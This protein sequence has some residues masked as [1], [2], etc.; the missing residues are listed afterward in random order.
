MATSLETFY[1][2]I[3]GDI[4]KF[5]DALNFEPSWQQKQLFDA[6]QAGH[7]RIAVKSGQGP[8][9]TAA[10]AVVALWRLLRAVDARGIVT[11][12]TMHQ[13]KDV[14]LAE[15]RL[16]LDRA[17]PILSQFF[18]VTKSKIEMC[19]R[20]DWGIKLMTASKDTNAQGQ[21]NDHLTF[22]AEEASGIERA[23]IQQIEGTLSQATGDSLFIQIGNPNTRDCAFFDC[24]NTKRQY[25]YT[26]TWNA[27]ESPHVHPEHHKGLAEEYGRDSDFYRVRILG[28]FPH[29]DP[30]CVMSSEDLEKCTKS[31][32]LALAGVERNGSRIKQFGIDFA[33]FGGDESAIFRRAGNSIVE[34]RYFA[35]KDPS[36]V[37]DVAYRMQHEAQWTN[38]DTLYIADATGMGQGIMHRFYQAGKQVFEFHNGGSAYDG[39]Q[40]ENRITEAFFDMAVLVKTGQ[41]HIPADNILIQQLCSRQFYTTKKGKLILESKDDYMHRG[42]ESP[43]RADG[44]VMAFYDKAIA[45]MKMTDGRASGGK[46][47]GLEVS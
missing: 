44:C 3:R 40:F 29:S 17:E 14:W 12:P 35:H 25:W 46:R 37:L 27:E 43:D 19:K 38:R 5:C 24:F 20:P 28:E 11:A 1:K 32:Y 42:F 6:V 31:N 15:A 41:C 4:Y 30:N 39:K 23:F 26:L 7:K 2:V 47:V 16:R 13:A 36:D 10:V 8:G 34:K 21:H 9:K 33:R 22:I 18:E 45:N